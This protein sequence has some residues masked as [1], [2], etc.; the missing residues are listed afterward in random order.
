MSTSTPGSRRPLSPFM[1]GPYYRPQLT[2]M[3]S[4]LHR[5]TGLVLCAGALTLAAWLAAVAAG[6]DSHARFAAFATSLPGTI[7]FLAFAFA[8]SY[9]WFNGLRHL[10]WDAGAGFDIRQAYASGWAVVAL[11]AVSTAGFAWVLLGAR[12]G[13]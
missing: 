9:H 2:S 13:A 7:L 5:I 11:A 10:F 4:I 12:G 8:L 1:I 6:P 3:L